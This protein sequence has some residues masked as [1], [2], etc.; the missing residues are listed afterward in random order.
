M[1]EWRAALKFFGVEG[2]LPGGPLAELRAL[3]CRE[4]VADPIEVPAA[5]TATETDL[6]LTELFA[7]GKIDN[8]PVGDFLRQ[9]G[10]DGV[11]PGVCHLWYVGNADG[12]G[13]WMYA[14]APGIMKG[15]AK[16]GYDVILAYGEDQNDVEVR[17]CALMTAE[18]ADG[19]WQSL[20][21]R[22]ANAIKI[23]GGKV[24]AAGPME[25]AM[26]VGAL[27]GREFGSSPFRFDTERM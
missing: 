2:K 12:G 14:T 17:I 13:T 22:K 10:C 25:E 11:R 4:I 18:A 7:A 8:Q 5:S 1:D 20:K 27:R 26:V 3:P 9:H 16:P 6:T 15:A 23:E 24:A 19:R 21:F